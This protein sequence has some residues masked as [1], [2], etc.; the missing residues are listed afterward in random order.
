MS[1]RWRE[2]S[3]EQDQQMPPTLLHSFV[4]VSSTFLTC[5]CLL[6]GD[7]WSLRDV[8]VFSSLS[9]FNLEDLGMCNRDEN[10]ELTARR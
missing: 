7:G 6:G 10:R 3:Q 4:T 1:R 2:Q 5:L 9:K 8:C